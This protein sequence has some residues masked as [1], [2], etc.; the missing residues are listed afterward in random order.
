MDVRIVYY[1]LG[2][3]VMAETVTMFIPF[4][5]ALLNLESSIPGFAVALGLSA[6]V[7]LLL[8]SNGRQRH[9]DLSLREGIAITGFGWAIATSLGMLPYVCGGYLNALD[10]VFESI[11]GF[12]GT[13]ATVFNTL[14]DLPQSILF[15]RMMTHWF[16]GLGIIVIFIALLPQTGQS[17]IYM[18]NA[19]TTGP[20]DD[21][22]LPRLRDMTKALFQMYMLFTAVAA[23]VY[24][25]CGLSFYEALTH[26]M[27]TIGAGG[28]STYD[29]SAMHFDSPAFEWCMTFFM[30]LAGGNFGLYY[31]IWQKGPG[32]IKRNSEFKAYLWILGLSILLIFLNMMVKM[33]IAA[34]DALRYAAFQ[35]GSLSTTG[36]VSA[37]FEQWPPFSKG[38]I[39]LLMI[40]G[41]CAGSTASGVK[42]VRIL[43]LLKNAWGVV[44][45]KL[46]PRRIVEVRLNG[47]RVNEET[48]LRVGQF[49]FLY[50]FFIAF[51]ALLLTLDGL[52]VFDAIGLSV[53]TMGNIGPAFGIAGATCTYAGLSVFSKSILCISM[54]LGRLEMFTLLVMLTPD[55]WQKGNRW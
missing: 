55:F 27:S 13:G 17:T 53:S 37:D 3:L 18:Y 44:H 35:V 51:W 46:S 40:C 9:A 11:S 14:E 42:V 8:Q 1:V 50:I 41:G 52:T 48:L 30:I 54:L 21:R 5:M 29:D 19:E 36:F 31:R 7:G 34:G 49:F 24:M 22:V 2:R 4:A 16:G 26:S 32:V 47:S 28:F 38:I 23:G 10:A 15:W 25:L 45:Q 39:L 6:S 12:T 20:T 33:D 43:L